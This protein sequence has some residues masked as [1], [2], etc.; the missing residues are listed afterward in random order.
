V[1]SSSESAAVLVAAGER[2]PAVV[3]D[4]VIDHQVEPGENPIGRKE[5]TDQVPAGAGD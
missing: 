4:R 5:S 3:A 1:V 2:A